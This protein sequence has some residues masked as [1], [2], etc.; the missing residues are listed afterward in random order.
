MYSF[1]QKDF[2]TTISCERSKEGSMQRAQHGIIVPKRGVAVNKE[3]KKRVRPPGGPPE[4]TAPPKRLRGVGEAA[5][6]QRE[7]WVAPFRDAEPEEGELVDGGEEAAP[8][9]WTSLPSTSATLSPAS[10]PL[11]SPHS[12]PDPWSS[13]D[14]ESESDDEEGEAE[15][16]KRILA[17]IKQEKEEGARRGPASLGAASAS[18]ASSAT[19]AAPASWLPQAGASEA[20]SGGGGGARKQWFDDALFRDQVDSLPLSK[21]RHLATNAKR[22][23]VVNDPTRNDYNI[24]ALRRYLV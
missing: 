22:T 11:P 16:I 20:G 8:S 5:R 24:S 15:K 13:S 19:P 2:E 6:Q 10:S 21:A 17:Q 18:A 14:S 3:L 1:W 23:Q 12:S 9:S 4:Q 7:A